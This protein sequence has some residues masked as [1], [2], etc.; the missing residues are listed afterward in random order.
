VFG[1]VPVAYVELEE[2]GSSTSNETVNAVVGE[3]ESA[4]MTS[5]ART[6][7]PVRLIIVEKIPVHA[8]GKVQK[9]LLRAEDLCVI[10]ETSLS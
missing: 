6:R 10:C 1:Q 4:L 5:F 8:T 2:V 9:K 3:I 7:R